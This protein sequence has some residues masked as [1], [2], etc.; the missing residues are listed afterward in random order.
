MNGNEPYLVQF[1][2]ERGILQGM[3][4]IVEKEALAW[5]DALSAKPWVLKVTLSQAGRRIKSVSALPEK[6]H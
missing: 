3:Y 6:E 1:L 2:T 4:T 5:F